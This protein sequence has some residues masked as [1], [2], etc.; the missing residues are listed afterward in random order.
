VY[1]D[2]RA[3]NV[4]R[5]RSDVNKSAALGRLKDTTNAGASSGTMNAGAPS[6]SVLSVN[7]MGAF[8]AAKE[9]AESMRIE[10]ECIAK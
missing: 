1:N 9:I 4:G 2:G 5:E 6:R 10:E 8:A 7:V 3:G